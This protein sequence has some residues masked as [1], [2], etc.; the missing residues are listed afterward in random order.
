MA[1][2]IGAEGLIVL[3]SLGKF[4]FGLAGARVGFMLA[5]PDLL[6]A[7]AERLGPWSISGP[8]RIAATL[9]LSDNAWQAAVKIRLQ[10]ILCCA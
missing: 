10:R 5:W 9:A 8:A 2:E 4:F 7:M 6:Q 3:R 1:A